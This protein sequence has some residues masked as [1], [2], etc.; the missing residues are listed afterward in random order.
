MFEQQR[1]RFALCWVFL[2]AASW[3]H[4]DEKPIWAKRML[5]QQ[6]PVLVVEKWLGEEPVTAGKFAIIEFWTTTCPKCPES[7][8]KL[9]EIQEALADDVVVIG[10]SEE[11]EATVLEMKDPVLKFASGIDTQK[12]MKTALEVIGIPHA[13]VVDPSGIV[14]WEG[15]P[16]N[17]QTRLTVDVVRDLIRQY[18]TGA[19]K[20]AAAIDNRPNPGEPGR[21]VHCVADVESDSSYELYLPSTWQA[22]NAAPLIFLF[23]PGGDGGDIL[24]HH[25]SA[26]EK[27]GWVGV[28][29]NK[30][31]NNDPDGS[32]RM[33][34]HIIAD[35]RKRVPHD[36]RREYLGG[37]SGGAAR[38]YT[39]TRS[40][41]NEFAGVVAHGGWLGTYDDQHVYPGRL[42]VAM[43][44]G[45]EDKAALHYEDSDAEILGR[46]GARVREFHFPGG[47]SMGPAEE[48]MA[49]LEEDWQAEGMRHCDV[50]QFTEAMTSHDNP[51]TA[52]DERIRAALLLLMDAPWLPVSMAASDALITRAAVDSTILGVDGPWADPSVAFAK[53][54]ALWQSAGWDGLLNEGEK[55]ARLRLALV[56]CA[57]NLG[58]LTA[59][60]EQLRGLPPGSTDSGREG[61]FLAKAASGGDDADWRIWHVRAM[62]AGLQGRFDDALAAEEEAID[63]SSE[64]DRERCMKQYDWLRDRKDVARSAGGTP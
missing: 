49:W 41:W 15:F 54:K 37:F 7:I 28:G 52:H 6:A 5:G 13:I 34:S 17:S 40:R 47:H 19:D 62:A 4:A 2:L 51:D 21:I 55:T 63:R 31:R 56:A 39:I 59:Y 29:C 26:I 11:S 22:T 27:A 38:S 14:R 61:A 18:G 35:V 30:L 46:S 23:S 64:G 58:P 12:R 50:P 9:N 25:Q 44:S 10:V 43:I 32:D 48:A 3:V 1:A 53:S 45:D 57:T 16:L 8:R 36:L 20:A 60:A 42:A 24:R 33:T